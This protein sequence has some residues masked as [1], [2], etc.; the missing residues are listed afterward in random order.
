MSSKAALE[1]RLAQDYGTP[2]AHGTRIEVRLSQKDLSS[3][4]GGSR[5]KVNRQLR[6]WEE[7]GVIGKEAGRLTLLRPDELDSP[8]A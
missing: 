5:E 8:E 1:R 4:V 6:L 3:L 2:A 7:S